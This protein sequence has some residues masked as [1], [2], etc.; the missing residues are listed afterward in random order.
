M[1]N[2]VL[3]C[4]LALYTAVMSFEILFPFGF[5][6]LRTRSFG[7]YTDSAKVA[8]IITKLREM[9]WEVPRT[10][11]LLAISWGTLPGLVSCSYLCSQSPNGNRISKL[12]TAVYKV[13]RQDKTR[14][15]HCW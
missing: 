3:S 7:G 12:I 9:E 6:V 11:P 15:E 13:N 5:W 14:Q 4:L 8:A 1:A 2:L 10:H